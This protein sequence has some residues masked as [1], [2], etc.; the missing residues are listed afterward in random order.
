LSLRVKRRSWSERCW[1]RISKIRIRKKKPVDPDWVR[2][3][4]EGQ[5][6]MQEAG[7]GP[8][9]EGEAAGPL[10]G[11]WGADPENSVKF[12]DLVSQDPERV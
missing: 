8:E 4:L 11:G 12:P 7:G 9:G 1:I 3:R 2:G 10:L 5:L 6:L